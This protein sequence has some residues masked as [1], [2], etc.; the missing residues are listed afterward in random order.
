MDHSAKIVAVL[1]SKPGKE[2]ALETLLRGMVEPSRREPGNLRWDIWT[3]PDV[4]GRFVLD[5]LYKN[6]DSLQAH[7][8]TEHFKH[9]LSTIGSLADRQAYVVEPLVVDKGASDD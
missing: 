5:E 1:T 6:T 8:E 7:R 3:D 4:P 2:Q 9:Y